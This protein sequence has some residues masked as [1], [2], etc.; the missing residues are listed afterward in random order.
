MARKMTTGHSCVPL[1]IYHLGRRVENRGE[2]SG[3]VV[4]WLTSSVLPES[5]Q[6]LRWEGP[7]GGR[8][9][10][11]EPL[12]SGMWVLAGKGVVVPRGRISPLA[13]KET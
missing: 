4:P 5:G 12:L 7:P 13:M 3:H 2:D 1:F 11:A 10:Q 8:A 9:E 6:V